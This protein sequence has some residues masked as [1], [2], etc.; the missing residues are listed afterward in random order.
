MTVFSPE[1]RDA[2][3]TEL[4]ELARTDSRITGAALTGSA[5][6]GD[7][8]RW[9]DIDLAFGVRPASELKS[10]LDKFGARMYSNHHALHHLDVTSGSWIYRVFLLPNTLQVDLAFAP[11]TDFGAR[12]ATFRLVFGHAIAPT[13]A[14]VPNV[15]DMI[16]YAW[17]YALHARSSLARGKVWQ[18]EYMISAMRDQVLA[19]ACVRLGLPARE[20]RGTD[21]L[22]ADVKTPLVRTLD[23][24]ELLR[25][26]QVVTSALQREIHSADP[27]LEIRLAQTLQALTETANA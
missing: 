4:L 24:G 26:L 18:A 25:A 20:G 12:A 15:Q 5:S 7:Q 6:V 10:V 13:P 2:L 27:Q 3:R 16:G 23:P 22:P 14:P 9:S 21:A 19:L 11:E 17:L 8:D 1:E